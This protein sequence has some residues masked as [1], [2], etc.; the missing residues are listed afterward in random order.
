MCLSIHTSVVRS[1]VYILFPDD[2]LSKHQW[3]FSKLGRCINVVEIWV[4][5]GLLMGYFCQLLTELSARGTPIYS[6]SDSN[7]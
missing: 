1:S 7:E 5:V 3:I 6:I 4:G 2:N